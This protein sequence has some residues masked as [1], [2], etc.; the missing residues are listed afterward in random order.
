MATRTIKVDYIARVEGEAALHVVLDGDAV[1]SVQLN[2]FEPPRFF[3]ALLRGR[4]FSEAID[5]TSRIC[6]I[7]PVAY[8]MSAAHAME[9][10]CGVR[11]DGP[12]RDLRRLLYCGEWIE[13]HVLHMAMLHLPDFLGYAD[14]MQ[15]AKDHPQPV[16]TALRLKALG[17]RILRLLGGREIHPINVRVGGFYKLPPPAELKALRGDID[18]AI[19]ATQRLLA[20]FATLE[21]PDLENPHALFALRHDS[22]YPFNEGRYA[23]TDGVDIA[24]A[25]YETILEEHQVAHSTALHSRR[26]DAAGA[27]PIRVGPAA[28]FALNR[29]CLSPLARAATAEYGLEQAWRNPYRSLQLR[30]VEVLFA[31][32]EAA[33]VIDGYVPPDRP[34]VDV[35]PR[36]GT[37]HGCTEAPRG[38][39]YHRYRIDEAGVIAEARIVPP[40]AVNQA[41]IED[42]LRRYV[43]NNLQAG[44]EALRHGCERVIRNFD[45]CISCS[46]HFLTVSFAQ[47][48]AAADDEAEARR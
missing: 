34:F 30:G 26:A 44:E 43:S 23:S 9:D 35:Q 18:G 16:Q 24:V 46:A 17:N 47:A 15:M 38:S 5:I 42:D 27:A 21:F 8:M 11:V 32:E 40:T 31:L 19:A 6:G 33:R 22:E 37:G 39:C 45:P 3:E 36:G 13:S 4:H 7:C 10:A 20:F 28:R 2:I 1:H 29:D 25:Y 48:G 14:A 41:A 12:L